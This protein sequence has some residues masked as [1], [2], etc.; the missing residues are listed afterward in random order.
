MTDPTRI[1]L[2]DR[3][4]AALATTG[5]V[6]R[7]AYCPVCLTEQQQPRT[8]AGCVSRQ[9]IAR[10][11]ADGA[12][13]LAQIPERYRS[14]TRTDQLVRD[15]AHRARAYDAAAHAI[16]AG[17]TVVLLRGP[18]GAG[19]T[20][21]L[22][23]LVHSMAARA[24]DSDGF[25]RR[26]A[27]VRWMSARDLGDAPRHERLG[28]R[29]RMVVEAESA[30]VLALDELGQET[31]PAVIRAVL[32]ERHEHDRLTLVTTYL[33]PAELHT[34]YDTGGARRLL[35]SAH[36]CVVEVRS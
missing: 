4:L 29:P 2:A 5:P 13:C 7:P 22:A 24:T 17:S 34:R 28:V 10:A 27:G 23:A 20:L 31:D 12:A 36:A 15:H 33:T 25:A 26:A 9:V 14:I 1:A 32:Y 19:K 18:A 8:C 21:V 30:T 11:S 35:E 16:H 6:R 3:A